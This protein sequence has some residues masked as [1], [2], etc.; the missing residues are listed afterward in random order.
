MSDWEVDSASDTDIVYKNKKTGEIYVQWT[1]GDEV[2]PTNFGASPPVE[3]NHFWV[4]L[5]VGAI[6]V[7]ALDL[8]LRALDLVS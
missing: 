6:G 7:F 1:A 4:G 2:T 8:A 5:G 3:K